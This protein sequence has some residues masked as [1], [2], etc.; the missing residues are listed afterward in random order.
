M[1]CQMPVMDGFEATGEIRRLPL[2]AKPVIIAMTAHALEGEREK[3]LAAG[4]DDYI[5][6]P[7]KTETLSNMLKRWTKQ[8]TEKPQKTNME[9]KMPQTDDS[10]DLGEL[11]ILNLSILESFREFQVPGAP[12]L[13]A[14]LTD[15]FVEDTKK[16]LAALH[17]AVAKKDAKAV[18][19]EAHTLKGS[20]GNIGARRITAIVGE[21]ETKADDFERIKFLLGKFEAEFK[22][23]AELINSM[24]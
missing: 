10:F 8:E 12:D 4:M 11:E 15:L 19:Q 5:S 17:E 24:R 18:E 13:V 22:Q 6:K 21:M 16:R 2:E 23:V 3:C 1:D 20:A 14:E 9:E 7:V